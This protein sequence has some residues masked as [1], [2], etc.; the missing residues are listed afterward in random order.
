[1]L[2]VRECKTG[3]EV[4]EN[5]RRVSEYFRDVSSPTDTRKIK[6]LTDAL[7]STKEELTAIKFERD[8]YRAR[9]EE[10]A[11]ECDDLKKALESRELP[12]PIAGKPVSL[13]LVMDTVC[14]FYGIGR[15]ELLVRARHCEIMTIRQIA[16]YLALNY[17]APKRSLCQIGKKFE[18]DHTTVI[19][20]RKKIASLIKTDSDVASVIEYLKAK[21]QG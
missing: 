9:K 18:R 3:A 2:A 4:M 19:N 16:M 5:V 13:D 8:Q 10:L 14:Q 15:D 7:A 1:M 12:K 21:L 6:A 20:G 17:C 11:R